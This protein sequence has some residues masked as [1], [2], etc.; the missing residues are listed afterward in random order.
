M[1]QETYYGPAVAC[2]VAGVKRGTLHSWMARGYLDV[3][4]QGAGVERPLS[5]T[6]LVLFAALAELYRQG[7]SVGKAA[8]L[9][10]SIELQLH[11]IIF[12][13]DAGPFGFLAIIDGKAVVDTRE[14]MEQKLTA[15][16]G[17]PKKNGRPVRLYGL[18]D[19]DALC[20]NVRKTLAEIDHERAAA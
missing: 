20:A 10:R 17:A 13:R 16:F 3:E 5:F 6:Q 11:D 12:E 7:V 15:I 19:L 14:H 2:R 4:S 1:R 8:M 9:L 18:L